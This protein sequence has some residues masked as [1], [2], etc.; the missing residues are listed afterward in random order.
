MNTPTPDAYNAGHRDGIRTAAQLL[1]DDYNDRADL[2]SGEARQ[3]MRDAATVA[4]NVV[5]NAPPGSAPAR[6]EWPIRH[7]AAS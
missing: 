2:L 1:A 7:M 6:G 3:A 5:D 4:Q